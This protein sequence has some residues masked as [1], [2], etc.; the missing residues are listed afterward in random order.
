MCQG[1]NTLREVHHKQE[2]K[3]QF[4]VDAVYAFA[5][6]LHNAWLDKCNG[7]GK[8][9]NALRDMDGGEF[10]NN[11]LLNVSFRGERFGIIYETRIRTC[12]LLSGSS[13]KTFIFNSDHSEL[14]ERR[15]I[16]L[17][18]HTIIAVFAY[19]FRSSA[20]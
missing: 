10:Y 4:V 12:E 13:T 2:P 17:H 11:Y 20:L 6:A 15:L 8:I 7:E 3:V 1:H 5:H 14:I 19:P 18:L 9:C 16:S